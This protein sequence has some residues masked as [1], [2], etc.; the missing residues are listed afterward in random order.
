M[1][2]FFDAHNHLHD[3]WIVPHRREIFADLAAAGVQHAV[4]NGTCESDWAEVTTLAQQSPIVLPSYGLHPWDVGNRGPDWQ[5]NLLQVLGVASGPPAKPETRDA[6]SES[7]RALPR[8]GEF[9]LDRWILDRARPDDPRLAGLRRAPLA[10]QTEV[11]LWQLDLAASHN[12]PAS[13]HCLDAWGHLHDLLR[14][15]KR[16]TRGFLLHS[17]SGPA[18]MVKPFADLG[19][20]FSFNGSFLDP[21]KHRLQELYAA[22]P[23]D[24]LLVETD[25]PAMR[26]PPT[27]EKFPPFPVPGGALANH[28]ANLAATYAALAELRKINLDALATQVETNFRRL[29]LDN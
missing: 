17:Y 3:E 20:H 22:L 12:L 19:A 11:F 28:P 8:A 29:F 7:T 9:G 23:A 16:P 15:A 10:E 18:E 6:K 24:R 4:V 1:P 25:A 14:A 5:K 21:R 26:L 27:H 13:I 2:A